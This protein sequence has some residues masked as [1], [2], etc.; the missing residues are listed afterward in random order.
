MEAYLKT[1]LTIYDIVKSDP[2]PDTYLCNPHEIILHA[3]EDWLLIERHLTLLAT[4]KLITIRQLDKIVICITPEGI[5][6]ARGLKNN[7]VNPDFVFT[8][9]DKVLLNKQVKE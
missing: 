4:E 1:L 6:K 7:F 5:T 2:S 9:E 8:Q 3:A